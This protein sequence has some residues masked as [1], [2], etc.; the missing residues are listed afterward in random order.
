MFGSKSCVL[1]VWSEAGGMKVFLK[2]HRKC[3]QLDTSKQNPNHS[4]I[5]QTFCYLPLNREQCCP[6]A[7]GVGCTELLGWFS[8][9]VLA[10]ELY[11]RALGCLSLV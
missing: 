5:R 7:G 9:G 10:G 8:L 6:A 1:L 4:Q 11:R 2:V 3:L